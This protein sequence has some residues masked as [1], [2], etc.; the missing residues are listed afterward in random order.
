M[1]KYK[2]FQINAKKETKKTIVTL[3][4]TSLDRDVCSNVTLNVLIAV[5]AEEATVKLHIPIGKAGS[6]CKGPD[7]SIEH[8]CLKLQLSPHGILDN[9]TFSVCLQIT[10]VCFVF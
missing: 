1:N 7:V 3:C 6:V 5:K 10:A 8:Y 2:I 4:D 9:D